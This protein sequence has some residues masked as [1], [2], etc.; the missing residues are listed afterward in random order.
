[1]MYHVG[2][3][4]SSGIEIPTPPVPSEEEKY[5]MTL[6]AIEST[7]KGRKVPHSAV[8]AWAKSL[9]TKS[10]LPMPRHEDHLV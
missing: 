6:E 4:T 5:Q 8:V 2:M 1:M 10:P 9:S 3:K 7:S